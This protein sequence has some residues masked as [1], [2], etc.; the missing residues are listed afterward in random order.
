MFAPFRGT[1]RNR[2]HVAV[3]YVE[4]MQVRLTTTGRVSGEPREV[5]LYAFPDGERLV[6]V[7]SRGGAATDPAWVRNLRADPHA[8][9]RRGRTVE[10]V[11]AREV[12]GAERDRLWRLVCDA[13]PLY[14]TYQRR[15]SRRIP[16]FV[17]EPAGE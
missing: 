13:F 11:R 1:Q 17:L 12:D 2:D 5:T 4:P 15:T 3:R 8:T 6:V 14:A 10:A 9:I 7:G 16:V